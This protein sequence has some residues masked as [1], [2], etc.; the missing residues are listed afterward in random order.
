MHRC[1]PYSCGVVASSTLV[2]TG[3][4]PAAGS[5]VGAG[6]TAAGAASTVAVEEI[7]RRT[8]IPAVVSSAKYLISGRSGNASFWN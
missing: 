2:V 5:I 6:N 4:I 7:I 8:I 3:S 1:A